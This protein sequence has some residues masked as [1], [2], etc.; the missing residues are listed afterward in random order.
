M[1]LEPR[2][3]TPV[4]LVPRTPTLVLLE[5]STALPL[6]QSL[7]TPTTSVAVSRTVSIAA[8]GAVLTPMRPAF[9]LMIE[10]VSVPSAANFASFRA[11]PPLNRITPIA[12]GRARD[13]V[14][15]GRDVAS[16][17]VGHG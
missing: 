16:V 11:S 8:D 15:F 6:G 10:S 12:L 1:L 9:S 14:G 7:L 17:F 2:T 4:L 3:P 5:P 13:F